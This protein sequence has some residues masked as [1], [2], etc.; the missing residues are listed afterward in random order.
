MLSVYVIE[1]IH[2]NSIIRDICQ[3][4]PALILCSQS[5]FLNELAIHP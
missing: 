5:G 1:I 3:N 4:A 2:Q